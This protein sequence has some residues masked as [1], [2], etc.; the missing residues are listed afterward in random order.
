MPSLTLSAGALGLWRGVGQEEAWALPTSP[1]TDP[2]PRTSPGHA[3]K[4]SSGRQ[5][6]LAP[7]SLSLQ[8][9]WALAGACLES[10]DRL[11]LR[12][13]ASRGL[14]SGSVPTGGASQ[15]TITPSRVPP[16]AP[17]VRYV[18]GA[19]ARM[20]RQAPANLSPRPPPQP[21]SPRGQIILSL[22]QP[23]KITN[24]N[25]I[26]SPLKV[27]NYQTVPKTKDSGSRRAARGG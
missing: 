5:G 17:A 12:T 18:N 24:A 20:H 3:A 8:P 13:E 16:A 25:S 26:K 11:S 2:S 7:A 6:P 22:S 19:N 23:D 10:Q 1:R 15:W 21:P 9:F 4:P 14:G 27:F